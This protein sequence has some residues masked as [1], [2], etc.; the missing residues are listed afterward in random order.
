[1]KHTD[2]NN[3]FNRNGDTI[4]HQNKDISRTI[5]DIEILHSRN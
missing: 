4:Y 1:M 3:S 5:R 2:I